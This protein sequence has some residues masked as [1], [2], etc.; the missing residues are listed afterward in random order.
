MNR[1]KQLQERKGGKMSKKNFTLIELLVVIAIIAILA[2]MLLPALSKARAAAQSIKCVS[3]LK[4]SA[5]I[6][7]LYANDSEGRVMFYN[8]AD[9]LRNGWGVLMHTDGYCQNMA[10]LRCPIEKIYSDNNWNTIFGLNCG[11]GKDG[12]GSGTYQNGWPIQ[13][14]ESNASGAAINLYS[15]SV[16]PGLPLV[17]DSIYGASG[18]FNQMQYHKLGLFWGNNTWTQLHPRHNVRVNMACV[19]GH[20][21]SFTPKDALRQFY[22]NADGTP[23]SIEMWLDGNGRYAVSL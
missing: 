19:D 20:A 2:S 15:N 1:K 9:A 14:M 7:T 3:N 17:A 11:T 16:R 5:L 6:L 4:Q 23:S 12:W 8:G 18:T 13:A 10:S 21:A 22:D